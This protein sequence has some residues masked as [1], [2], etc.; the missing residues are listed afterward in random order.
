MILNNVEKVTVKID[1]GKIFFGIIFLAIAAITL[2]TFIILAISSLLLPI[3]LHAYSVLPIVTLISGAIGITLIVHGVSLIEMM[4][5]RKSEIHKKLRI[6]LEEELEET[7][8]ELK[9]ELEK[10]EIES[11]IEKRS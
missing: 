6:E 3:D 10:G 1:V 7:K 8:K 11:K 9:K 2:I 4:R 5:H